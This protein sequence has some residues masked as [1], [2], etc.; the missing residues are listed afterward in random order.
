VALHGVHRGAIVALTTIQ[1]RS[2]L[3]LCPAELGFPRGEN[4]EDYQDL[5][6]DF[7]E[8]GATMADIT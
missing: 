8:I 5:V 4:L 1:V 3:D 7:E 2:R 6:D